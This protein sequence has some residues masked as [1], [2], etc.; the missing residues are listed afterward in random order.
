M[1]NGQVHTTSPS[2]FSDNGTSIASIWETIETHLGMPTT[3]KTVYRA[4]L[5]YVDKASSTPIAVMMSNDGGESW[6][7][8]SR[9]SGTGDGKTHTAS[10]WFNES[11]EY[12]KFKVEIATTS[13]EFQV[14]GLD[15]EFEPGG[16]IVGE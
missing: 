16:E 12:F 6:I 5:R 10:F 3:Y 9:A 4:T 7:G 15:I 13:H 11:G 1:S 2:Y 14:I 8:A